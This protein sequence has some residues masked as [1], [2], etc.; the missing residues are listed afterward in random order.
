M[1]ERQS[2]GKANYLI[3]S[4]NFARSPH[5]NDVEIRHRLER[6]VPPTFIASAHDLD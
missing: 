4:E 3:P 6:Q 2:A 5:S 1:T